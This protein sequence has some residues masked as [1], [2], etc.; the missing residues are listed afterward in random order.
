MFPKQLSSIV[1]KQRKYLVLGLFCILKLFLICQKV[2][3]FHCKDLLKVKLRFIYD[4]KFPNDCEYK[5]CLKK[6]I[7]LKCIGKDW[8]RLVNG[9]FLNLN[10]AV[11]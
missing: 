6:Y 1:L 5:D 7:F 4:K 11:N 9:T 2:T 8:C 3:S 10:I